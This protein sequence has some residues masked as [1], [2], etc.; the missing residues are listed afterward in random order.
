[1]LYTVYIHMKSKTMSM[2]MWVSL[3]FAMISEGFEHTQ[4]EDLKPTMVYQNQL[5]L[6]S[7]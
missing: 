7:I 3:H 1:M 4:T 2:L 6:T 5:H